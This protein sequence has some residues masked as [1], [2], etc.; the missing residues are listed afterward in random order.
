MPSFYSTFV[1][2]VISL[3]VGCLSGWWITSDYKDSHYAAIIDTQRV[4]ALK[5][6]VEAEKKAN[7]LDVIHAEQQ[8][9]L[10]KVL[11]DN[12]ALA[13]QL[14]GLRDPG[15]K[16]TNCV[17]NTT[18]STATASTE[19]RL[20]DEATQFLLEFARQADAAAEYANV[21]HAWVEELK[22]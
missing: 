4:Q 6:L 9:K 19:G 7:Q 11:A 13:H 12:H 3:L 8:V 20:S 10:D 15:F 2:A 14:G 17:P 22:H 5:D 18:S 21:C 1:A 16:P